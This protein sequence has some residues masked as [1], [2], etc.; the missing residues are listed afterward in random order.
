MALEDGSH[1]DRPSALG[2]ERDLSCTH[3]E[4]HTLGLIILKSGDIS[5]GAAAAAAAAVVTAAA[6]F[7]S[8]VFIRGAS[9]V[10][11]IVL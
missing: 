6:L 9:Q 1:A 8:P 7:S 11:T 3:N 5:V 10:I 2:V 4:P